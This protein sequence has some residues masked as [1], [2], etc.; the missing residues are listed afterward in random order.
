MPRPPSAEPPARP[1][2]RVELPD[3]VASPNQLELERYEIENDSS[4]SLVTGSPEVA[5][6]RPDSTRR[7]RRA[8]RRLRLGDTSSTA[9]SCSWQASPVP[10]DARSVVM[11]RFTADWL[12][13][14]D[15]NSAPKRQGTRHLPDVPGGPYSSEW[16]VRNNHP[17]APRRHSDASRSNRHVPGRPAAPPCRSA[18]RRAPAFRSSG[19]RSF[20]RGTPPY[21]G[22]GLHRSCP[23][24]ASR[25]GR[26][27][28]RT[29]T[30][31]LTA[32]SRSAPTADRAERIVELR[33]THR[34]IATV[35]TSLVGRTDELAALVA[36]VCDE[37]RDA[38]TWL[39]GGDAGVGKSRLIEELAA[40]L[41]DEEVTV[42]IG[43]VCAHCA[44]LVA[45]RCGHRRDQPTSSSPRPR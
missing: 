30:C 44:V 5:S 13:Q 24:S 43:V 45:V 16:N 10:D 41:A 33:H 36:G 21:L 14:P 23:R 20:D 32:A 19:L 9:T 39:I 18:Q 35:P 4:P 11:S 40:T 12:P 25:G 28:R 2:E 26:P 1:H 34:V 37:R 8:R 27:P 3:F 15:T 6:S 17:L 22:C 38:T 31:S 42:V 29:G 7:S